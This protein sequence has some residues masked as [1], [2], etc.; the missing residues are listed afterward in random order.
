MDPAVVTCTF[1]S[2]LPICIQFPQGEAV[3]FPLFQLIEGLHLEPL[4]A[5]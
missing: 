2:A 1:S 3:T 4:P 5:P